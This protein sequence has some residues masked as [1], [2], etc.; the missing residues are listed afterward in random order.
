MFL[1]SLSSRVRREPLRNLLQVAA[2]LAYGPREFP[3]AFGAVLAKPSK[4]FASRGDGFGSALDLRLAPSN[5]GSRRVGRRG[6]SKMWIGRLTRPSVS[7]GRRTWRKNAMTALFEEIDYRP[8]PIGTLSLRRRRRS[9]DAEDI[10]EIKL[11]EGYLMSSLFTEGEVA[12]AD[13]ALA[14]LGSRPISVVVG[15][16]GLGYTAKAA[17]DHDNLRHLVVIEAIPEVIEWHRRHLLPLGKALSEDARC[18]FVE[19]NF[20]DMAGVAGAFEPEHPG[21]KYDAVLVDIDHSPRH[22]LHPGNA[23]FYEVEG[24]LAVSDKLNEG[25][26]FALWSTDAVDPDFLRKLDAVFARAEAERIEFQNPYQD[27]PAFNIIYI[28]RK[29]A[30]SA[31][32]AQSRN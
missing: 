26:V 15:G 9:A 12:L 25:G 32:K 21:R 14:G 8:S 5:L 6:R 1:A 30:S 29:S 18:R 23:S 27:Q 20:F 31:Q 16:L 7:L 10:Y 2:G 28:A 19:G 3:P 4:E 22:L 11:D 13:R 24:L 17:L